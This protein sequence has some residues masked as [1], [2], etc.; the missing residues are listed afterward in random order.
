[1]TEPT[2]DPK[3]DK[4]TI[5]ISTSD[6]LVPTMFLWAV[7][8]PCTM[9]VCRYTIAP[10]LTWWDVT[11]PLWGVPAVVVGVVASVVGMVVGVFLLAVAAIAVAAPPIFIYAWLRDRCLTVW[12]WLESWR[13]ARKEARI[14]LDPDKVAEGI[15]NR[16]KQSFASTGAADVGLQVDRMEMGVKAHAYFESD[17]GK[18]LGCGCLWSL[19]EADGKPARFFRANLI[20]NIES[21]RKAKAEDKERTKS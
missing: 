16:I 1:M 7:A 12:G 13:D 17:D 10:E 9:A 8:A 14:L 2:E 19:A 20:V 21:V 18:R 6:Y 11:I 5:N 4:P 15:I 3:P